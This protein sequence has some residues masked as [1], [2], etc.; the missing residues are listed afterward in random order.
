MTLY[1]GKTDNLNII[2]QAVADIA[3]HTSE[4]SLALLK[5]TASD[6]FFKTV[7]LTFKDTDS[8]VKLNQAVA[9]IPHES[10]DYQFNPHVSLLYKE[11][12][13]KEKERIAASIHLSQTVLVFD[14]LSIVIPGEGKDWY[15][16]AAWQM[17]DA[18]SLSPRPREKLK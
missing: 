10:V 7:F 9:K 8:V 1:S 13:L 12:P 11:L 3:K 6:F 15:D 2:C 14:K 18:F 17:A 4:I 5:I 16:I